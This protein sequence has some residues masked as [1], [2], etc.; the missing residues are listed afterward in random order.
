MFFIES[1]DLETKCCVIYSD[2]PVTCK[3]YKIHKYWNTQDKYLV[4]SQDRS[5]FSIVDLKNQLAK[6]YIPQF[7]D[8]ESDGDYYYV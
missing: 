3:G 8:I 2:T 4:V 6:Y 5:E 1:T 7:N